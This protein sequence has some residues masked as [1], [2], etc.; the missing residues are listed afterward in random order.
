MRSTCIRL[1]AALLLLFAALPSRAAQSGPEPATDLH[2]IRYEIRFM[3]LHAAEVLAW[4][5]VPANLKERCR[6][7]TLAVTG[8]PARKAYLEVNA[9]GATHE[10][11]ARALAVADAAP[12][13]QVFQ[14]ILL[15]ASN[16]TGVPA[17]D[18]PPAA[19]KALTDIRSF[20]PYKSYEPVDAVWLRTTN[21]AEGS[22]VGS[23]GTQY[24]V[25]MRFQPGGEDGK[26]LFVD[27]F[28]LREVHDTP[29]PPSRNL[30]STSFSMKQGETIVVG[31]AKSID[32]DE[33][34]VVLLTA[35]S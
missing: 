18:L 20:L 8:D 23:K 34:L 32:G 6:V 4:D 27:H 30:I 15:G 5:Q 29:M 17:P 33:A 12:K 11:I 9:D 16:R 13:T 19:Q 2:R 28:E 7:A 26:D 1:S 14:L 3:D 21:T 10:R 22:L 35:V 25:R 31:T 24:Q